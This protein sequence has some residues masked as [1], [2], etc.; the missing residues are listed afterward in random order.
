MNP[1]RARSLLFFVLLFAVAALALD[2]SY[3]QGRG[4]GGAQQ[5]QQAPQGQ[6]GQGQMQKDMHQ[7]TH[8]S[9]KQ[10]HVREPMPDHAIYGQEM[11]TAEERER[12]RQQLNNAHNDREWSQMR[13]E[14]QR[15][16]QA[17]AK[18]QG[19]QLDPPVFGEHMMTMEERNRYTQR[20]Q[21]AGTE[22]ERTRIQQEH[23]QMMMQR[24]R[25]LGI[26][27]MLQEQ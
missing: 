7:Q 14:H 2:A 24:A 16:M 18:A 11:M 25:E 20:I 21:A 27:E 13:A 5:K 1:D 4:S 22:E 15:E 17:R 10:K 9:K 3:N 8:K 23:Q 19:R 26:G 12:Y 6:Q